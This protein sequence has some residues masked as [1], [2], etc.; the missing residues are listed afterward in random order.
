LCCSQLPPL[1]PGNVP[2][3]NSIFFHKY[4][5]WAMP[6]AH[7]TSNE[8]ELGGPLML[9]GA[10][11]CP[12]MPVLCSWDHLGREGTS[13]HG[14]PELFLWGGGSLDA[15]WSTGAFTQAAPTCLD[16]FAECGVA[17][18]VAR[19]TGCPFASRDPCSVYHPLVGEVVSRIPARWGPLLAH[20]TAGPN[21][22]QWK[23][24]SWA[25]VSV[26]PAEWRGQRNETA[27][28][29]LLDAGCPLLE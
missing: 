4:E 27:G 15:L 11:W 22:T 12:P 5:S 25:V 21:S 29:V 19:R 6:M 9:K 28:A 16:A 17:A 1:T 7:G 14:Q 3:L 20:P 2:E 8:N 26:L 10:G 24:T 13:C 23:A 18:L